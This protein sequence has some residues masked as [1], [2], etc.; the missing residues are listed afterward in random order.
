MVIKHAEKTNSF[1][2]AVECSVSQ[3]KHLKVETIKTGTCA[4]F[5]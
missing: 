4:N 3:S 2:I 1:E 5:V